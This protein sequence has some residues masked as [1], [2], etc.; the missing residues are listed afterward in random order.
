M[1]I[2]CGASR[3]SEK[4]A[5]SVFARVAI[6]P[7]IRSKVSM[8]RLDQGGSRGECAGLFSLLD[9]MACSIAHNYGSVL[10][11]SR[12][13]GTCCYCWRLGAHSNG[14]HGRCSHQ[15]GESLSRYCEILQVSRENDERINVALTLVIFRCSGQLYCAGYFSV[16]A[17]FKVAGG[18]M[19]KKLQ[20]T[21]M[22]M[23]LRN[24]I[25]DRA[26]QQRRSS[27]LRIESMPIP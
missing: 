7:S 21:Q 20:P 15:D 19:L 16:G 25:F 3:C 6:M 4:E 23:L 9:D 5:E 8:G 14:A 17:C 11:L 24:C 1:V 22:K 26:L 18:V 12:H 10:E 27:R 13:V 2:V